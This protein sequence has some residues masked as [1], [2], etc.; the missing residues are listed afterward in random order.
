MQEK[1]SQFC[2]HLVFLL[3]WNLFNLMMCE[4]NAWLTIVLISK[5]AH[6]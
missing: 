4:L 2:A 1:L 5:H 6:R 3:N